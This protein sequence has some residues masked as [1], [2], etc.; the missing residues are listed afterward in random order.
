MIIH[1]YRFNWN[2]TLALLYLV[3]MCYINI[4]TKHQELGHVSRLKTLC[5]EKK[6]IMNLAKTNK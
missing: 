4:D 5:K 2:I 3:D 1:F 6:N